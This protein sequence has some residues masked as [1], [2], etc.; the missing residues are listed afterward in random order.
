MAVTTTMR[1]T[2]VLTSSSSNPP[3]SS[4]QHRQSRS[5][6]APKPTPSASTSTS[7]STSAC[8]SS[9]PLP[10]RPPSSNPPSPQLELSLP[11]PLMMTTFK[12]PHTRSNGN[13]LNISYCYYSSSDTDSVIEPITEE[14]SEDH[15]PKNNNS[16]GE[17]EGEEGGKAAETPRPTM[18]V[19]GRTES[20]S[21]FVE[22]LDKEGVYIS[23]SPS[24]VP[25]DVGIGVGVGVGVRGR[26]LSWARVK[27][28]G[29]KDREKEKEGEKRPSSSFFS[30]RSSIIRSRL[31]GSNSN[32]DLR[33]GS[34]VAPAAAVS[35][36]GFGPSPRIGLL[37]PS[38][39]ELP[40]P[41]ARTSIQRWS[42][43]P[44]APPTSPTSTPPL[45]HSSPPQL[46]PF[47]TPHRQDSQSSEPFSTSYHSHQ[48][49]TSRSHSPSKLLALSD[50][51]VSVKTKGIVGLVRSRTT[52]GKGGGTHRPGTLGMGAMSAGT[53][54]NGGGG[55][56]S[57]RSLFGKSKSSDSAHA[58]G[59][60]SLE[61]VPFAEG[62][63]AI[64]DRRRLGMD[65]TLSPP[66]N[67]GSWARPQSM[68]FD[69][70]EKMT[71]V[72]GLARNRMDGSEGSENS[73]QGEEGNGLGFWMGWRDGFLLLDDGPRGVELE[74]VVLEFA[75]AHV[76]QTG[77]I[78]YIDHDSC[79][80]AT[81]T[82]SIAAWR[83]DLT[84]LQCGSVNDPSPTSIVP[85]AQLPILISFSLVLWSQ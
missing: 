73:L 69:E 10:Q 54:R 17:G 53:D 22:H 12:S 51:K 75:Q 66:V 21:R 25:F 16:N 64:E 35:G 71:A 70:P 5:T 13:E 26:G 58:R 41:S 37:L 52:M 80:S 2:S 11:P 67:R 77:L 43:P 65:V 85:G 50:W 55:A 32:S 34:T 79:P 45:I 30:R 15:P 47:P 14:D 9:G 74:R 18:L 82:E 76:Q 44:P 3:H 60:G 6:P 61:E 38:E 49:S 19:G 31:S 84:D 72:E 36:P 81:T 46:P 57:K 8:S 7:A 39:P 42:M 20:Y 28:E 24:P 33:L 29:K 59:V 40:L 56:F 63:G 62:G 27:G 1:M 68:C 23:R 48:S 78:T 83:N 4:L